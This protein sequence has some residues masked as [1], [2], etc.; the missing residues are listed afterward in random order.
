M[1]PRGAGSSGYVVST[2]SL[3]GMNGIEVL[4]KLGLGRM[5]LDNR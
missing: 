2:Q 3:Q 4:L 5:F 1:A